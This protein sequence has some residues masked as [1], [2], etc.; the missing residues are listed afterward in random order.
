[1]LAGRATQMRRMVDALEAGPSHSDFA[2][3]VT[4]VRGIG[5]TATLAAARSRAAAKGWGTVAVVAVGDGQLPATLLRRCTQP[6]ALPRAAWRWSLASIYPDRRSAGGAAALD[7]LY[8]RLRLLGT[9]AQRLRRGVLVTVD[10]LPHA[11]LPEQRLLSAVFAEIAAEGLPVAFMAAG[12]PTLDDMIDRSPQLGFLQRAGRMRLGLV[13]GDEAR[14][15]VAE[16]VVA[17]GKRIDSDALDTIAEF[18]EGHPFR[19]QLI[20]WQAWEGADDGGR[21]TRGVVHGAAAAADAATLARIVVPVW[22]Q[23]DSDSQDVLAAMVHDPHRSRSGDVA[24]RVGISDVEAREHFRRLEAAGAVERLGPSECRFVYPVMRRW[25][26]G[27]DIADGGRMFPGDR[28]PSASLKDRIL[29]ARAA[30]PEL[31]NAEIGRRVGASRSYV[32]KVLDADR[33]R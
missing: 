25:L 5:K 11:S 1:M 8:E 26:L 24:A 16:P 13:D 29:A 2:M 14:R 10:E 6:A 33:H 17:T 15:A 4:G 27:A 9:R 23:L 12:M 30:Q 7:A 20:G 32:G 21:I 18:A 22:A 28:S 3:V 31:S 19:L